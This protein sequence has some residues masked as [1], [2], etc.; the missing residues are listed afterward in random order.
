MRAAGILLALFALVFK[1]MLPPGFML[2]TGAGGV[3]I[4]LCNGG[5]ALLDLSG[6]GAPSGDVSQHCPFAFAAT[7]ALNAPP[8]ATL[9]APVF[10]SL[11]ISAP[12]R[13]AI[14]VHEHTGPPLPARGPPIQA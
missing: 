9:I 7:P 6:D 8:A 13:A 5:S 12:V 10:A 11:T 2:E 4:T 3:E 14:G 1:A